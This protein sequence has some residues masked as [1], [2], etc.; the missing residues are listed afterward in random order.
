MKVQMLNPLDLVD[1]RYVAAQLRCSIRT[2]HR[3]ARVRTLPTPIYLIP[4]G[5]MWWPKAEI[6][7]YVA[8]RVTARPARAA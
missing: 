8:R 5:H 3:L 1:V 7:D 6:D 2:V 4:G